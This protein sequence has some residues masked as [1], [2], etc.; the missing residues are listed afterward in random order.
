MAVIVTI[1]KANINL[2]QL[3]KK[4]SGGEEVIITRGDKPVA[5]LYPVW[6]CEEKTAAGFAQG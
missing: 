1:H 5:R 3:I 2:S 4:V 6:R